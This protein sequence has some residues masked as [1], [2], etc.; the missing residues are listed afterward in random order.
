MPAY[1][2]ELRWDSRSE[3]RLTDVP[4]TVGA[5]VTIGSRRWWVDHVAQPVSDPHAS[6]RFVC[7]ESPRGD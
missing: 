6:L 1:E 2:I 5:E 7:V 4:L 3:Y